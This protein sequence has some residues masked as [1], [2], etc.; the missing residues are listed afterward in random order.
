MKSARL[1]VSALKNAVRRDI[2]KAQQ[3]S[4]KINRNLKRD[5]TIVVLKYKKVY[6]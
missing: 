4:R 2:L 3:N 5:Y 6:N 1:F